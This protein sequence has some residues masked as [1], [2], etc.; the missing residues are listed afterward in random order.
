MMN[1]KL[2]KFIEIARFKGV[3]P[4][5]DGL[6]T[7]EEC[8][9]FIKSDE[10]LK[11]DIEALRGEVDVDKQARMKL[12]LP[13]FCFSA[14]FKGS[15]KVD[16]VSYVTGLICVD[17]DK[18]DDDESFARAWNALR[19]DRHTG[20]MFRSPS[21]N[22]IK[23]V[24]RS[25]CFDKESYGDTFN[26]VLD[27]Y[28]CFDFYDKIDVKT[29]DI[30]RLCFASYDPDLIFNGDCEPFDVVV[31]G[32]NRNSRLLSNSRSALNRGVSEGV[33]RRKT[34]TTLDDVE[35]ERTLCNAERY[36][37]DAKAVKRAVVGS[38][39]MFGDAERW[40]N[41]CGE[42]QTEY[43]ERL[44]REY[45]KLEHDCVSGE[46][47]LNGEVICK[48]G[49][50]EFWSSVYTDFGKKGIIRKEVVKDVILDP[51]LRRE[52]KVVLEF[53]ALLESISKEAAETAMES[54]KSLC[55]FS[56][57][58]MKLFKHWLNSTYLAITKGHNNHHML[59]FVGNQGVGKTQFCRFLIPNILKNYSSENI[60]ANDKRDLQKYAAQKLF[61]I[62]DEM[63]IGSNRAVGIKALKEVLSCSLVSYRDVY[64]SPVCDCKK[65]ASFLGTTNEDCPLKDVENRRF[66]TVHI[67]SYI[68]IREL[69]K[70]N[71]LALY[72]YCYHN[73]VKPYE[74]EDAVIRELVKERNKDYM[75]QSEV[76]ESFL[77][78]FE[79]E[80]E[81][82]MKMD[83]I[84]NVLIKK[85]TSLKNSI[86]T[87]KELSKYMRN[88]GIKVSKINGCDRWGVRLKMEG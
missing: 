11:R 18:F 16:N 8:V 57:D 84:L 25:L 35:R 68:N 39:S 81:G 10:S 49:K 19:G 34:K 24:V 88:I 69:L 26:G 40:H 44:V 66:L 36:A 37:A 54:V 23:V 15:R 14:Q 48:S 76:I 87:K 7:I 58:D 60:S 61:V 5:V 43:V 67:K 85:Y 41:K 4:A 75:Q 78:M 50:G 72:A 2:L 31:D 53:K 70:I 83:D 27:Y 80:D 73:P 12:K 79:E 28:R 77:D 1:E 74:N 59:L 21:G 86:V 13:S 17:I 29:S 42:N 33:I 82:R 55:G 65:I 64:K 30:S 6:C 3:N 9:A 63:S 32:D 51:R 20:L 47:R 71:C 45:L 22:G 56:D 46:L 52:Y 38:V 62:A